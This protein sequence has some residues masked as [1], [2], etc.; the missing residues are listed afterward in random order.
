MQIERALKFGLIATVGIATISLG[1]GWLLWTQ[2][3]PKH[4][5][6]EP[7]LGFTL[8]IALAGLAVNLMFL[9]TVIGEYVDQTMAAKGISGANE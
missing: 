1:T 2:Y 7:S 4:S 8:T 3:S 9:F 5:V 6:T